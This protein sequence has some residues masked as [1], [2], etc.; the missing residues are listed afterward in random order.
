MLIERATAIESSSLT[1]SGTDTD[2]IVSARLSATLEAHRLLLRR[3]GCP[4]GAQAEA[5]VAT[6]E[7]L[8]SPLFISCDVGDRAEPP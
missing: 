6:L 2:A 3:P 5:Y 1:L 8:S 4:R 7:A